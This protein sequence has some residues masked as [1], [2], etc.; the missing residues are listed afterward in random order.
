MF[1]QMSNKENRK[2]IIAG[3]AYTLPM[4]II[5]DARI[6]GNG[7]LRFGEVC[8]LKNKIPDDL[9]HQGFCFNLKLLLTLLVEV[10]LPRI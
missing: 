8:L 2:T 6:D 4:L 7:K 10:Y 9:D 3:L 5:A 1:G